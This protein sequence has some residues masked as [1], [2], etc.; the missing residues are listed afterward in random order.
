MTME[1]INE[2]VARRSFEKYTGKPARGKP[3]DEIVSG[4]STAFG[5]AKGQLDCDTCGHASPSDLDHCPFCGVSD[6]IEGQ[7][8]STEDVPSDS[9]VITAPDEILKNSIDDEPTKPRARKLK[10]AKPP[11]EVASAPTPTKKRRGPSVKKRTP[12]GAMVVDVDHDAYNEAALTVTPFIDVPSTELDRAVETCHQM[13]REGAAWAWHLGKHIHDTIYIGQTWKQRVDAKGV[14]LYKSFDRFVRAELNLLPAFVYRMM[15]V[16]KEFTLDQAEKYGTTRL[17]YLLSAAP[18]DRQTIL[19][20]VDAAK[21]GITAGEVYQDVQESRADK[22]IDRVSTVGDGT[23]APKKPAKKKR[24]PKSKLDMKA[25]KQSPQTTAV[26]KSGKQTVKFW[27]DKEQKEPA[28]DLSARPVGTVL[29]INDV[30]IRLTLSQDAN[31]KQILAI[32]QVVRD[33]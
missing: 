29:C 20:K 12:D 27:L 22:N 1:M 2:V 19:E 11:V 9:E 3:L 15:G 7:A 21:G 14:G 23:R 5:R 8:I 16:A 26:L 18:E 31:T 25:I 24:G 28:V 30:T 33:E 13:K 6:I 4:L 17:K 32:A 10:E